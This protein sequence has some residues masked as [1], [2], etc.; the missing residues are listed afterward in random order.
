MKQ[1]ARKLIAFAEIVQ[2][3]LLLFFAGSAI[4]AFALFRHFDS[5]TPLAYRILQLG[6]YIGVCALTFTAGVLLWRS[7]PL[8][9]KLSA[10]AQGIQIPVIAST[11]F[12]FAVK[13][14]FGIWV[15]CNFATG[16]VG[17][18]A[19][20]IGDTELA[21][22][23]GGASVAP[24]VEINVLAVCIL[25]WLVRAMRRERPG[26]V[27]KPKASLPRR[28]SRFALK[29]L[30]G[31]AAVVLIPVLA[32]WTYNRFDEAPTPSAQHWFAP[33]QHT[34]QD[35]ENAWLYMLG[36]RAAEN[37]DPI[38]FGRR[39]LNAYE[40]RKAQRGDFPPSTEEDDLSPDPL[41]FQQDD[42]QGK[43]VD[44]CDPDK[45]DCLEWAKTAAVQLV[46][47]ER[48]NALLLRRYETLLDMSRIDDVSTPSSDEPLPDTDKE[49]AL[50]RA[51]ILRDLANPATRA[52]ALKRMAHVVEFWQR[53]EQPAPSLWMKVIAERTRERYM[54][55]LDG[56]I[57]QSGESG[58]NSLHDVIDLIL[59]EPTPAQREWEGV[60][61]REALQFRNTIDKGI[62]P[63]P[64]DAIRYCQSGCLKGWLIAQFFVPQ[65]TRNLYARLWDAV[66]EV[67]DG[68]PRKISE[69]NARVSQIVESAMPL[70]GSA[71]ETLRRIS[72]NAT[73]K[74][75]TIIAL[76]AYL[77]YLDI[78]HDTEALRRMLLLKISA[79][80]QYISAQKMPEYLAQ[81]LDVLVDPYTG[82][83]FG[84]DAATREIRFAP[85]SK[86]WKDA[87]FDV[88]YPIEIGAVRARVH[89]RK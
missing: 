27:E 45:R 40:A 7:R 25:V 76:P 21:L 48:A 66:L 62:F 88:T 73:G 30:L 74:I 47:L 37:D 11:A 34:V 49:A 52:D 16:F 75:M 79:L 12:S 59:R 50:Y 20:P 14:G 18:H 83:P 1:F 43:Q 17:F 86:K 64:I 65:A 10:I 53:V 15:F 8:G 22:V 55:I 63:G 33:V 54:R 19:A 9:L 13:L 36:L 3:L 85:R 87:P 39:R 80:K 78:Q 44:L 60:L 46:E 58:L 42:T 82:E 28:V 5:A 29:S 23:F 71:K 56:L 84:W 6:F 89:G 2:S 32:L 57:N 24:V 4:Q 51:L 70:T 69:A 72:Y 81:Q 26:Y 35:V 41:P 68:D 67:H 31:L 77:Q 38:A 61:H